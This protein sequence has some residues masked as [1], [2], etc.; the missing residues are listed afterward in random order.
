MQR[1]KNVVKI[2]LVVQLVIRNVQVA[3]VLVVKTEKSMYSKS[4]DNCGRKTVMYM[5][6]IS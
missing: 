3:L 1:C 4:I 2:Q 6:E 5:E